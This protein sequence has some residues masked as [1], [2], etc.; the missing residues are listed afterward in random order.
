MDGIEITTTDASVW[1]TN[2]IP[3]SRCV[4]RASGEIPEERY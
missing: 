4:S 1:E 2:V 3:G